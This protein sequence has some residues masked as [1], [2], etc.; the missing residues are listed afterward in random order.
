MTARRILDHA[1]RHAI[2]RVAS[3]QCRRLDRRH[4]VRGNVAGGI[5]ELWDGRASERILDVLEEHMG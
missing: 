5:P 2:P 1:I 4:F 3:C